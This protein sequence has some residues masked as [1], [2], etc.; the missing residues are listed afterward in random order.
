MFMVVHLSWHYQQKKTISSEKAAELLLECLN[1]I[2]EYKDTLSGNEDK[3]IE[4][5]QL[6]IIMT[7][8]NVKTTDDYLLEII[9]RIRLSELEEVL[10]LMPFSSVC[11]FMESL[12]PLLHHIHH[13]IE[14]VIRSLVFLVQTLHKPISSVKDMMPILK[15]LHLLATNRTNEFRDLVGENLHSLMYINNIQEEEEVVFN[16][17]QNVNKKRKRQKQKLLKSVIVNI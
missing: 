12:I 17:T 14:P 11:Y 4:K 2:K 3:N 16:I 1:V 6:P 8:F 7:A 10:L 13:E 9:K 5:P 15:Q